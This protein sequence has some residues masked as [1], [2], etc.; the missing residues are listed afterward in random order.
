MLKLLVEPHTFKLAM[1][2]KRGL[3]KT[4]STRIE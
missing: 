2:K 1:A 4:T 3:S